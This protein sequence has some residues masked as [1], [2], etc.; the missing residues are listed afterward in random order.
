MAGVFCYSY[1]GGKRTI[2]LLIEAVRPFH[3]TVSSFLGFLWFPSSDMR[4]QD[5]VV[6]W[7]GCTSCA[8]KMKTVCADTSFRHLD[9]VWQ[10][11]RQVKLACCLKYIFSRVRSPCI[12]SVCQDSAVAKASSPHARLSIGLAIFFLGSLSLFGMHNLQ[13]NVVSTQPF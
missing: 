10:L 9:S 11:K 2:L 7:W 8:T 6:N 5:C 12:I 3:L 1:R 4:S 13:K